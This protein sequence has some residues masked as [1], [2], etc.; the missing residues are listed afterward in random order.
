MTFICVWIDLNILNLRLAK[1]E[2]LSN[3][4]YDAYEKEVQRLRKQYEEEYISKCQMQADLQTLKERYEEE[5]S[6][7][8][9]TVSINY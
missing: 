3:D 9:Q 8:N 6:K 2:Q 5:V 4:R 1:D 7:L